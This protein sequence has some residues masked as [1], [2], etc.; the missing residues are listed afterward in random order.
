MLQRYVSDGGY[1]MWP[2]V[3]IFAAVVFLA[4]YSALVLVGELRRM[5]SFRKRLRCPCAF[6]LVDIEL[7]AARDDSLAGRFVSR[8]IERLDLEP[9]ATKST[10]EYN[11]LA[12]EIESR[13]VGELVWPLDVLEFL[14]SYA[15]KIGLTGT[16]LGLCIH[17]LSFGTEGSAEIASKAMAVALYTTL[18]ALTIA[19]ISEPSVYGMRWVESRIARELNAWRETIVASARRKR[20]EKRRTRTEILVKQAARDEGSTAAG[21][22]FDEP[23]FDEK[24]PCED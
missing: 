7:A 19:L 10:S 18:G 24:T 22:D 21:P 20:P 17:F 14:G 12:D 8:L 6:S 4:A 16:I 2:L 1:L 13:L 9:A 3:L 15:A 23:H 11:R 5:R